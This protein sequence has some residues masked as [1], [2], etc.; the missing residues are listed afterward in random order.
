MIEQKG[1]GKFIYNKNC[2]CGVPTI[3]GV[4]Y[5]P[6]CLLYL[7]K[8]GELEEKKLSSKNKWQKSSLIK[9]KIGIKNKKQSKTLQY[10]SGYHPRSNNLDHVSFQ[11][12]ATHK[13][14]KIGS[15]IFSIC[16]NCNQVTKTLIGMGGAYICKEC[17]HLK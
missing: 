15:P 1:C 4:E 3:N 8:I 17:K 14:V 13:K 10:Q 2:K 16:R 5:C 11:R 12:R 7:N 9:Q 6:D